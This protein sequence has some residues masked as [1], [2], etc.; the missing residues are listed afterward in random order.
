MSYGFQTFDAAGGALLDTTS[1]LV[2]T[3]FMFKIASSLS[4]NHFADVAGFDPATATVFIADAGASSDG[5]AGWRFKTPSYWAIT[6]P[7]W[8]TN[9][10]YPTQRADRIFHQSSVTFDGKTYLSS[11]S[12]ASSADFNTDLAAGIWREVTGTIYRVKVH[13]PVTA[14]YSGANTVNFGS[15]FLYN[16]D[17]SYGGIVQVHH[18]QVGAGSAVRNGGTNSAPSITVTWEDGEYCHWHGNFG[19]TSTKPAPPSAGWTLAAATTVANTTPAIV[20]ILTRV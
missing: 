11:V 1:S 16:A 7:A 20:A 19:T 15:D 3:L 12:H 8:V 4:L 17:A 6:P 9:T 2:R 5:A 13:H 18:K 10:I 14:D